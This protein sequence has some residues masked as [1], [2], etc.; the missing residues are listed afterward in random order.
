MRDARRRSADGVDLGVRAGVL[1]VQ[2]SHDRLVRYPRW[3]QH[4]RTRRA[5]LSRRSH[6]S[7]DLL[8]GEIDDLHRVAESGRVVQ[9][10]ELSVRREDRREPERVPLF[11]VKGCWR[12]KQ[13]NVKEQYRSIEVAER[14]QRSLP[15]HDLERDRARSGA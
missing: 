1:V 9:V 5:D 3:H 15:V 6:R 10:E 11:R 8:R 12:R 13:R 7:R 4:A 14:G 2:R